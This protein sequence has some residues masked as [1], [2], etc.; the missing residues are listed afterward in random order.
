MSEPG[1]VAVRAFID[2]FNAEDLDALAATLTEDVEIQSSRG[3]IEGREEAREWAT[4]KPSGE[5]H[6][7]LVLDTVEDV[8][9]HA[10]A[11]VRREWYWR[12]RGDVADEHRF[13][14]VATLRDGL[15]ARWQPCEER[16]EALRAAGF[17]TG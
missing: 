7:R 4:R 8:G 9:A 11:A 3:V 2:A 12:E 15:I 13:W 10:I 1:A 17:A 16:D 6:Q 14:V 5:L